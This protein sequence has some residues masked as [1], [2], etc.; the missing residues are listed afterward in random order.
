M[1]RFIKQQ[2]P[3]H[4]Q[5]TEQ[6]ERVSSPQQD[7]RAPL[8][9]GQQAEAV[10]QTNQ[11]AE[12]QQ[13]GSFPA[14]GGLTPSRIHGGKRDWHGAVKTAYSWAR[15]TTVVVS[16]NKASHPLNSPNRTRTEQRE[17]RT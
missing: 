12:Q 15:A 2:T 7:S 10:R 4:A 14:V 1:T 17:V 8:P 6:G 16:S 11:Q 13:Q 5:R 9:S 3:S